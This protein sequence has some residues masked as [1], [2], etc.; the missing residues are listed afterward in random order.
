MTSKRNLIDYDKL[1]AAELDLGALR[2]AHALLSRD[3]R[4][5]IPQLEALAARGSTMSMLYLAH[6]F[7]RGELKSPKDA[8]KWHRAAY[9]RGA[10]PAAFGLGAH[11]YD[12][13]NIAE[14]EKYFSEGVAHDDPRAMFWLARLYRINFGNQ[15]NAEV[16]NLLE[17]SMALGHVRAKN[18]LAF[19]LMRGIY[20]ISNV[21]R[22]VF[23]YVSS[24]V[25]G[26]RVA[27][28]DPDSPLLW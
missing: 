2:A 21:P 19:L 23:L 28:K 8:E 13:G 26:V 17:R 14:A 1:M 18:R 20:G 7:R 16:K 15:K 10:L 5:A 9:E 6:V 4:Q 27:N 24:I 12:A 22:G 25:D 3:P 11:Y